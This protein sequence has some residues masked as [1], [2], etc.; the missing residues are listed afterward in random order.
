MPP[1][2]FFASQT[3]TFDSASGNLTLLVPSATRPLDVLLAVVVVLDGASVVAPDGWTLLGELTGS[4]RYD[5][6]V[7][8]RQAADNEPAQHTFQCPAGTA[9]DP[10]AVLLLYRGLDPGAELV[11]SARAEVVVAGTAFGAPSITLGHYSD[12]TLLAYYGAANPPGTFA[13]AAG[14][15]QRAYIAGSTQGSLMVADFLQEAVGPTPVESATSSVATTGFAAAIAV[16]A[17][18]TL[19]APAVVPDIPGAIGFVTVGV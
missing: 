4:V 9:P 2:G 8:R 15:T 1:V 6:Y 19:P 16:Q 5:C 11:A 13:A 3:S 10:L 18:P 17:Q 7:F 12:L 14:T